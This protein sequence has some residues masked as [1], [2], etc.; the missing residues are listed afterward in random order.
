M[1]F[2]VNINERVK[3]KL[4]Q[5]GINVLKEN[6]NRMNDRLIHIGDGGLGEF[7]LETDSEGYTHFQLWDLMSAFG[8][9][10]RIGQDPPFETD[11]IIYNGEPV[12]K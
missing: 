7:V 3:V 2:K 10:L 5:K 8:N 6:H 9:R 11:I 1:D 12:S 4:T